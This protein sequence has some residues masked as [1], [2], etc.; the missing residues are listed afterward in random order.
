MPFNLTCT[1]LFVIGS[2]EMF[3]LRKLKHH[4]RPVSEFSS[5]QQLEKILLTK[6]KPETAT[7]G[8]AES[9]IKDTGA[10]SLTHSRVKEFDSRAQAVQEQ[11]P[12]NLR[13]E[14][15]QLEIRG[16]FERRVVT[17]L[18]QSPI[19]AELE[20][21]IQE[22]QE[23]QRRPRRRRARPPSTRQGDARGAVG[24]VMAAVRSGARSRGASHHRRAR[25]FQPPADG[26]YPVPRRDQTR[27]LD[28]LRQS[29]VLNSLDQ[30]AR[31]EIVSEVSNLVQQQ[32]VT[33]ALSGEFRGVLEFHI[34]VYISHYMYVYNS[35]KCH[36]VFERVVYSAHKMLVPME[37]MY[38]DDIV[39]Y[40]L[41][42]STKFGY[43]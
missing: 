1:S 37:Y 35:D 36:C 10:S 15:V 43:M 29:P 30:E 39:A 24:R 16:L 32:L 12:E 2:D 3:E 9:A 23:G 17:G 7:P 40:Y 18:L 34:Q 42:L 25:N 13:P 20:R 5:R 8:D 28:H 26:N 33:S 4:Q 31:E 19:Q 38:A 22:Q 11:S 21:V 41:S 6:C 27:I 14:S